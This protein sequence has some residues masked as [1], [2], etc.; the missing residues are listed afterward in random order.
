MCMYIYIYIEI[1]IYKRSSGIMWLLI[2]APGLLLS[3]K[4]SGRFRA[5]V[6]GF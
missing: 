1:C 3:L 2:Q 5:E 4:Q 6:L